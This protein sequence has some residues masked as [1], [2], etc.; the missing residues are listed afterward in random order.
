MTP[1]PTPSVALDLDEATDLAHLLDLIED[2][3]RH[4][5]DD[6]RTDLAGYLDGAGHGQLAAT[7]L[8]ATIEQTA[9]TLHRR[10]KQATE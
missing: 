2:W 1:T 7:G 9:L 6:A 4:S 5:D 8:T 3:L 10:L